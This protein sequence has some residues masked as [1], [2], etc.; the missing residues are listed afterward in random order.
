MKLGKNV[1][2]KQLVIGF[3]I[4]ISCFVISIGAAMTWVTSSVVKHTYMEKATMTAELLLERIDTKKYE[5]LAA[6]PQQ[7]ELYYELQAQLTDLLNYN[8]I[9]YMYVV[10]A[11]TEGEEATT[12]VDAGDLSS[13]D[14]Y[15]LGDTMDGVFYEEVLASI[16]KNGS[17][18]EYES[19]EEFGDLISSYVPLTDANGE[20]FAVL[21]VDDSF[22]LLG[23]IQEKAMKEIFPI[24]MAV[25]LLLSIAII[26]GAGLYLYRLFKP[27]K[28]MS[29]ATYKLDEGNLTEAQALMEQTNLERQTSITAFGRAFRSAIG[30]MKNSINSIRNVSQDVATTTTTIQNVS[31]TL[32]AAT[33]TLLTSI[34]DI[35]ENVS[36][37]ERSSNEAIEAV[38]Q[39]SR[40]VAQ[41][42]TQ[43]RMV[44]Q[45]LQH[46]STLIEQS[47]QN[48]NDATL[49]MQNMTAT[50][51]K[52]ATNVHHLSDKYTNIE[53]MVNV[54]QGIADQTNLLALNAS[55][56]AARV[57]DAG[58]GFA[59][60]ADEVRNLAELTKNSAEDIR[61]QI[62]AFKV[63]TYTVLSDM[64]ESTVIV[65]E[66]A[67]R[68]QHI[69]TDLT[70]VL[71]AA[72]D[73]LIE[74]HEVERSIETTVTDVSVAINHSNEVSEKLV[75][76]TNTVRAAAVAQERTLVTL[77]HTIDDLTRTVESLEQELNKYKVC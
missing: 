51:Q 63:V 31:T 36:Q 2:L 22:V 38:Q 40:D 39:M 73:V 33:N 42:A 35:S 61:Q 43:V 50:V 20:V 57:G 48:A 25:V 56:E 3:I 69:S 32:D 76:G 55:I 10:V 62:E 12:L 41:I 9:T 65:E 46:T 19:T 21:G 11:P 74:M 70:E 64:T 14:V 47:T 23:S 75:I 77:Q 4:V 66:G 7:N 44:V 8:P 6:N 17:Y 71:H 26:L 54:I 29:A 27:I 16:A 1:L 34:D 13:D 28:S 67:T 5:Q 52:T 53:S 45:H 60:V 18:S 59:V 58:K 49:Q 37:Q 72:K 15:A 30:S 68:V 24:V